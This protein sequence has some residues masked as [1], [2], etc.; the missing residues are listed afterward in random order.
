M[1]LSSYS[2]V[3]SISHDRDQ[4][5]DI[6]PGDT[7]RMGEN[8]FPHYQV[9]AVNGDKAWV[10]NVLNGADALALIGRCRKVAGP[11]LLAAE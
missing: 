8:H 3:F 2:D 5:E 9:L 11:A 7:V 6:R 10:R 4:H 1:T